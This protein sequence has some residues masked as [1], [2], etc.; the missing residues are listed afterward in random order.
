LVGIFNLSVL[1]PAKHNLHSI[2]FILIEFE[3]KMLLTRAK[4]I[5][6][7]QDSQ[8]VPHATTNRA[9]KCLTS[10]IERDQV[11]SQENGRQLRVCGEFRF[12]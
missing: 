1:P 2:L 7:T 5:D 3:T 10:E 12:I 11:L 9:F 4:K 8:L 6:N